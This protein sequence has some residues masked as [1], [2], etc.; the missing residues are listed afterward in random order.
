MKQ[1]YTEPELSKIES[2]SKSALDVEHLQ[3]NIK[4]E[5]HERFDEKDNIRKKKNLKPSEVEIRA[6]KER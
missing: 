5:F 2:E 1:E 3:I 4:T 6:G